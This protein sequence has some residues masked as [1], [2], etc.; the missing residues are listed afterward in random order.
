MSSEVFTIEHM[1]LGDERRKYRELRYK[2]P[3]RGRGDFCSTLAFLTNFMTSVEDKATVL[4]L[5]NHTSYVIPLARFFPNLT[6]H[7]YF[8]SSDG[9][10]EHPRVTMHSEEFNDEIARS[11]FELERDEPLFYI[12]NCAF[13]K[14]RGEKPK[15]AQRLIES[16]ENRAR[17]YYL[18][19][20]TEAL[21]LFALPYPDHSKDQVFSFLDGTL[22]CVPHG[23]S[24]SAV[25][26]IIPNGKN[27]DWN[28]RE[29]DERIFNFNSIVRTSFFKNPMP[30]NG[31]QNVM[32]YDEA[33]ERFVIQKYLNML[34]IH[35]SPMGVEKFLDKAFGNWGTKFYQVPRRSPERVL[36]KWVYLPKREEVVERFY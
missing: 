7:C 10:E 6:F 26:R 33:Y 3:R 22:I 20:P 4:F 5:G 13:R 30:E 2:V 18:V 23:E 15:K 12:A 31:G 9:L 29:Y 27:R 25:S 21:V 17:W 1:F 19:R 35:L 24:D 16:L 32:Q 36:K 34:P 28:L 8:G 14:S 11:Y